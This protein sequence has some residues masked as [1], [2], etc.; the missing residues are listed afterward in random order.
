MIGGVAVLER[1]GEFAISDHS[2]GGEVVRVQIAGGV[3]GIV[4]D[5]WFSITELGSPLVPCP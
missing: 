2:E 4:L 1:Q 3:R 5:L